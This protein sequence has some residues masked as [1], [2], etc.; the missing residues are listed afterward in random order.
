VEGD[1][2]VEAVAQGFRAAVNRV[3]L[4]SGDGLQV[5]WVVSLEARDEG[6]AEA[7]GEEGIFAVGFLAASPAGIAK[8]VDVGRPEGEAVVAAGVVV[9]DG[10]V[11]FGARFGGDDVGDGV[12][13][14]GVPRGAEANGLGEDGGVAGAGD[15][16]ESF[17]PPVVH[18]N[19]Q[20]RD[21][22]S[23]VLHLGDFFLEGH[24]RDEIVDALLDGVGRVKIDR[25]C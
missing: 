7:A 17:V 12:D 22:G 10:V 14:I 23:D 13:Q 21:G 15:A 4:W 19:L 16:V 2:N 18:G 20:T 1:G 25:R 3:V 6:D 8:D 5:V 11:V 9:G 24:A